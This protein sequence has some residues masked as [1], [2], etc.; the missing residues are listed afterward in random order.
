MFEG[1]DYLISKSKYL[2]LDVKVPYREMLAEAIA[3]RNHYI[4]YRQD[5]YTNLGWHSLPIVGLSSTQPYAWN[6]YNFK[7]AREAAE[8]VSWTEVSNRCP[9]T[10]NWLKSV[11]PSNSYGRVRFMLLEAGGYIDFHKDT[12]Y[13]V[14]AAI[15]IALNNPPKCK[16]HWKDGETLAFNPGDVYAMN[17]SYEHS[18]RNDSDEDRYHMI[19]HHYD[20]TDSCKKLFLKSMEQ[21]NVQGHFHYS[22]E[23]F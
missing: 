10:T 21:Q 14:L 9:T 15:N 7:D 8:H 18:V 16:W 22:T 5:D 12:D 23:L 11:Y 3:L 19:I 1:R 2:K 6:V 13:P 4:L 20:F 17:L